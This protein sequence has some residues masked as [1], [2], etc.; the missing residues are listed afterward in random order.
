MGLVAKSSSN[1]SLRCMG[2]LVYPLRKGQNVLEALLQGG[3]TLFHWQVFSM[4]LI[5]TLAG[6]IIGVTPAIGGLVGCALF[7]PFMFKMAPEQA[8]PALLAIE[9]V[10]YTGGA[11][12]AILLNVPGTGPSAAT[13]LDGFPMTQKGEPGRAMGA[14]IFS[15]VLGGVSTVPLALL[16]IPLVIPFVLI[17][18]TPDMVFLVVLGLA[19]MAILA[20]GSIIKGL[21]SGGLGLLFAFVGIQAITCVPRF[22]F[23]SFYLLDG[24]GLIPVCLGLFAVAELVDMSV[25]GRATILSVQVVR[26]RMSDLFEGVKDVF[27]HLWLFVRC[28]LIGYVI[29]LI[30]GIGAEAAVFVSYAHAKQ[31]SKN[32]ETFGTGRVEGV[33]APES[34]N[35]SKEAGALLTTLAFGIP[36]SAGMALVLGGFMMVGIVPGPGLLIDYPELCFTMLL[37]IV[38]ANLIAGAI[39]FFGAP[40]LIKVTGVHFHYLFSLIIVLVFLGAFAR[41]ESLLAILVA[42][43]F[44]VLGYAMKKFGYSRPAVVLAFILGMLFEE[45]FFHALHMHGPLFFLRPISLILIAITIALLGSGSITPLLKRRF[46]RGLKKT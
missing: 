28:T 12:T 4:L 18:K 38:V 27:R 1:G 15:S 31:S 13:M 41:S 7:L 43:A 9:A 40:Y 6:V 23:G 19:F 8:L 42:L 25:A 37:S 16:M 22:T 21:I 30:P 10:S 17:I 2:S 46:K 39:C 11:V 34:A 32:P 26:G 33:I 35:N 24:L 44:G 20:R 36:G 29:G 3:I 45:N 14:A 5:G